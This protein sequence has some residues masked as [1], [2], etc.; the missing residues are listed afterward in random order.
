[1]DNLNIFS[2]PN[3]TLRFLESSGLNKIKNGSHEVQGRGGCLKI[4]VNL[5]TDFDF[6]NLNKFDN[7]T[8]KAWF[9]AS[10]KNSM[11]VIYPID[12]EVKLDDIFSNLLVLDNKQN[13]SP[14]ELKRLHNKEGP[15][16]V[17]KI[18]FEGELPAKVSIYGQVYSVRKYNRGPILCYRC[19][20]WGHGVITCS[21][22]KKCGFCGG[23]HF[24]KDCNKEGTPHCFHCG[25]DHVTGAK[26]CVYYNMAFKNS[27]S[28]DE[29]KDLYRDLNNK[30]FVSFD[31]KMVK[32]NS[33]KPTQFKNNLNNSRKTHDKVKFP[34]ITLSNY[35]ESLSDD[36]NGFVDLNDSIDSYVR[37]DVS[38]SN[39]VKSKPKKNIRKKISVAPSEVGA[40]GV[41]KE[42]NCLFDDWGIPCNNDISINSPI[43][44]N[45]SV[46]TKSVNSSRFLSN[47]LNKNLN[48]PAVNINSD[49]T[50]SRDGVPTEIYYYYKTC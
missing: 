15:T 13:S 10:D 9:P 30:R 6:S 38:Y 7:H 26:S 21:S 5:D 24:L 20:R 14:L 27:V 48:K 19:S 33:D 8:L 49:R 29:S 42:G 43:N 25:K 1:M 2:N 18:T 31:S 40:V 22:S 44:D 50:S 12:K 37:Q 34:D 45:P 17:I 41:S 3:Q 39:V 32:F 23:D 35:Y 11:G 28:Y 47:R 16:D 36:S 4:E 46:K